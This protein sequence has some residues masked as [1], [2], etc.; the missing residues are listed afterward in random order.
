MNEIIVHRKSGPPWTFR[1]QD[2]YGPYKHF[3]RAGN[4]YRVEYDPSIGVWVGRMFDGSLVNFEH[5]VRPTKIE[6][7]GGRKFIFDRKD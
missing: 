3:T 7:L 5:R 2:Y 6:F 4:E 1:S